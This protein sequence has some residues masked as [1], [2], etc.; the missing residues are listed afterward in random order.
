MAW[1]KEVSTPLLENILNQP[2]ALRQIANYQFGDGYEAL[3]RA[4]G[5]LKSKKRIILSGMGASCFACIPFQYMLS[6]RGLQV[7]TV[8]T[9]ELLYFL[10]SLIDPDTAVVL[11]SRSG[12]SVE[13]AKLI[14]VLRERGALIVGVVNVADSTLGSSSDETIIMNC[15]AD[16]MV[17]IQTYTGTVAVLALLAAAAFG[18]LDQARTEIEDT[19]KALSAWIPASVAASERWRKFL[20]TESALYL[21]GRGSALGAVAEGVLLMHETAKASAVGMQAGQ[22]RHG[23]V[24]VVDSNFRSIIIATQTATV[25]F[26]NGLGEDLTRMGGQVRWVGPVISGSNAVPLCEWPEGL[27]S[28]FTPVAEVIP[29]Q[30]SSYRKAELRGVRPGDF[31]WAPLV[32]TSES[33]LFPERA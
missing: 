14:P 30:L 28:R 11:V 4:A 16:Q 17:A 27:P 32:T 29:L 1:E 18:E 23:P 12:E 6:E 24:E 5:L 25:Q 33:S 13:V 22:F 19:S 10:P 31:R 15:P 20:E 2:E 3:V 7:M 8:D 26:D 9:A 21:L